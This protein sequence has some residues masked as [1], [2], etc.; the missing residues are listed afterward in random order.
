M[1]RSVLRTVN[2]FLLGLAGLFLGG[3]RPGG[4]EGHVLAFACILAQVLTSRHLFAVHRDRRQRGQSG[5]DVFP[6]SG[7]TVTRPGA[8]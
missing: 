1:F 8:R 6:V 3:Q 2:L 7:G 4:K 5:W